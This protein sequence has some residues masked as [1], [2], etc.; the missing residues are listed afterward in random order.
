MWFW[1]CNERAIWSFG[2]QK[3]EKPF[4]SKDGQRHFCEEL[5]QGFLWGVAESSDWEV[6]YL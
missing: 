5:A 1:G 3:E 6:F 2:L 4:P